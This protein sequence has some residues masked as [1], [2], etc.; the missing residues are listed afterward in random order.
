[1]RE[2]D[3][4]PMSHHFRRT[5]NDLLEDDRRLL[6]AAAVGIAAVGGNCCPLVGVRA[7]YCLT[8]LLVRGAATANVAVQHTGHI[9]EQSEQRR[10]FPS[11]GASPIRVLDPWLTNLE[12]AEADDRARRTSHNG[13]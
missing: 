4:L 11:G 13:T 9:I 12:G 1:M 7:L 5:A 10:R 6:L 2:A 8:S 3:A